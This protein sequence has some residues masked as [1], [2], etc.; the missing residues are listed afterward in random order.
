M[1][2]YSLCQ[3]RLTLKTHAVSETENRTSCL[4]T[5]SQTITGRQGEGGGGLTCSPPLPVP[6]PLH[7]TD[8]R[9][10]SV[11]WRARASGLW[12][13]SA[14]Y[15]CAGVQGSTVMWGRGGWP[16]C[17]WRCPPHTVLLPPLGRGTRSAADMPPPAPIL[18]AYSLLFSLYS[19]SVIC[20]GPGHRRGRGCSPRA[21]DVL[22][23]GE[24]FAF[25]SPGR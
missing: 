16:V 8:A 9:T 21:R 4:T 19:S 7:T 22:E 11:P 23:V 12:A 24:A 25:S 15:V 17:P 10:R 3:T 5:V 18:M 1:H 6:Q 13:V 2:L 20:G 14:T